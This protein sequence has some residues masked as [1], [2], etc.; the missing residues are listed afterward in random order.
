VCVCVCVCVLSLIYGCHLSPSDSDG[1]MIRV[2]MR[3]ISLV[4]H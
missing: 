4:Y 3:G 2:F 1:D